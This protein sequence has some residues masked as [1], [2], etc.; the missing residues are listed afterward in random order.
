MWKRKISIRINYSD[1]KKLAFARL[2]FFFSHLEGKKGTLKGKAG[3]RKEEK[4][5]GKRE[6]EKERSLSQILVPKVMCLY[7]VK[8]KKLSSHILIQ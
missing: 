1:I 8:N 3:G 4:G 7:S 2:I 6:R 5:E